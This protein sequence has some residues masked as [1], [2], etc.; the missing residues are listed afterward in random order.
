MATEKRA[1]WVEFAPDTLPSTD[2]MRA[3][4]LGSY[5]VFRDMDP[6]EYKCWWVE[7]EAGRWGALYVFRSA[8]EL[9][10]YL[11]SERWTKV[12][13][14]KYGCVPTWRVM[15]VGAIVSKA[16]ISRGE[17]SWLSG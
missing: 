12:I 13:P 17:E 8:G 14:E 1:L 3:L 10:Q 7:Q 11:S 9:D 4:F 2:Q 16:M 6:V 5:P 15:E